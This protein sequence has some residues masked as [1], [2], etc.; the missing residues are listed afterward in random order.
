MTVLSI[1]QPAS[2]LWPAD[3][4]IRRKWRQS[5]GEKYKPANFSDPAQARDRNNGGHPL[6]QI[7]SFAKPSPA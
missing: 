3:R 4:T 7:E 5:L 2:R 6:C 1:V